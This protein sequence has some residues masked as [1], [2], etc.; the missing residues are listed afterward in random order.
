MKRKEDQERRTEELLPTDTYCRLEYTNT[1]KYSV[2]VH[3]H[4]HTYTVHALSA[5]VTQ[6]QY[7]AI[8]FWQH[9]SKVMAAI[10]ALPA[11]Y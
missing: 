10:T 5:T 6:R 3:S 8:C 9:K 2:Y 7:T 1:A 11:L 4:V